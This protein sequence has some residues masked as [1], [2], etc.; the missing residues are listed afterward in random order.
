MDFRRILE[1]AGANT[2]P[3]E[4][5]A[6]RPEIVSVLLGQPEAITG[7]TLA[8]ML[9][10]AF[11]EKTELRV[12]ALLSRPPWDRMSE[13]IR[14]WLLEEGWIYLDMEDGRRWYPPEYDLST[15]E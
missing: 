5:Q 2:M 6:H 9:A 15:Y 12:A 10:E 1:E 11:P 3:A 13:D 8:Q 4:V 14:E 7:L